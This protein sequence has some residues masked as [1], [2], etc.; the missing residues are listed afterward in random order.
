MAGLN[1]WTDIDGSQSRT[2]PGARER[3]LE[4][5]RWAGLEWDEG[6]ISDRHA[7]DGAES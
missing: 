1:R 3:L 4:D 7:E 6:N 2:V 5:L